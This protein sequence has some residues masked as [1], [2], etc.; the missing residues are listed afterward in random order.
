MTN[1]F[2]DG[3]CSKGEERIWGMAKKERWKE[4]AKHKSKK[5]GNN[6]RFK[7]LD[8]NYRLDLSNISNEAWKQKWKQKIS[9]RDRLLHPTKETETIYKGI[10]CLK[11]R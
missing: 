6:H 2:G 7:M 11:P 4:V 8:I 10:I 5:R 9:Q 3:Q 1:C